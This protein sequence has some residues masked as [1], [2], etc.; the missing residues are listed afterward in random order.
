MTRDLAY[1]AGVGAAVAALVAFAIGAASRSIDP[2]GL[3]VLGI[4][5]AILAGASGF[6]LLF[7]V[8]RAVREV[9]EA[10][11]RIALGEF[12]QGVTLASGPAAELTASFNIMSRTLERL[13]RQ[14][15]AEHARLDAV[16]EAAT[17]GILAL[18]SDTSVRFANTAAGRLLGVTSAEMIG[19]PLIES[20]RDYEL[21]ALA[22]SAATARSPVSAVISYGPARTPLR[23]AAVPIAGGGEWAILLLL[24]DLSEVNRVDQVRRDFVSN[25][26]HELRTPLAS[27]RA[28]AETIQAGDV[29]P[30]PETADF[31]ARICGQVDRLAALVNEL[32]ELSRIESG[33]IA[34]RPQEV[35]V[36]AI[37]R[38]AAGFLR[39]RSEQCGVT[40]E[41]PDAGPFVEADPDALLRVISNLLDNAI[42]FSPAGGSVQVD[43]RAEDDAVTITVSDSGPGIPEP[44]LQRVFERF[45]K[46]D[47]SRSGMGV[48]LGL[49]IVKH[50]VRSHGGHVEARNR[51]AGGATFTV[52]L[53][54]RFAG[55]RAPV[56]R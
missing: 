9:G 21:D 12:G 36:A 43:A 47:S 5:V 1:R 8:R 26:S 55:P 4:V 33:A 23:A 48:G 18:A 2:M 27:I 50:L 44:D 19:R 25:V 39:T 7:P 32:L 17:D 35:D 56:G 24:A 54:R 52:R 42:K 14:M 29:E 45:Y 34:L 31:A 10:A 40:I 53:P 30:G 49:A 46:G 22:R 3:I 15:N 37:A 51:D 20:A 16:V 38:Q 28:L 11:N 6:L 13:F 41:I